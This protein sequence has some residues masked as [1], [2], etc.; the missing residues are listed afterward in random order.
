MPA[1]P[2]TS[3]G[4]DFG[5]SNTVLA[6][7]GPRG[8]AEAVRFRHAESDLTAFISALCFWEERR[9]GALQRRVEGGPW[10]VDQFLAG[11]GAHRFIQSFKTFAASAAFKDTRIFGRAFTFEDLLANFLGTVLRHAR[12]D[13]AGARI[14]IGRPVRFAGPNPDEALALER[15]RAAFA[16]AGLESS[17]HVYEP[18]GAAFFYAQRLERDSTVLVADFGGGT[19]DFSVMRFERDARDPDGPRRG[20]P[21]AHSGIGIA[22][23]TFD[24]RIIDHVVSPRLGKGGSYRSFGK[25]LPLPTH[26]FANFARWNQLAMMKANGDLKELRELARQAVD[27]EAL[28]RFIEIVEYDQGFPLYRAVSRAKAALSTAASTRF[29]FREG[30]VAI[31]ETITREAFEAWIAEDVQRIDDTVG[32]ALQRAGLRPAQV[33]KV[34]L[35]GGSSFIP[36]IRRLFA[37]R[38]G[39]DRLM[40]GDQFE[41]I[42]TGLAL[43]GREQDVERWTAKVAA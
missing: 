17:L 32:V 39:E 41:S 13:P 10:A 19:S 12:I 37:G 33:D 4:I 21:L 9:D 15:Y 20:T 27:P 35:T 1:A 2:A 36:A 31:E 5:T 18:V 40:S 7:A 16:R 8:P 23:D 43:I 42:A 25:V 30:A 26:Y 34:F 14:V 28:E 29:A 24:Y 22:G 6:L 3:I 11:V 38:F